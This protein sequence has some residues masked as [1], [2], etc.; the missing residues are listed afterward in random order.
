MRRIGVSIL[1]VALLATLVGFVVSRRLGTSASA[2]VDTTEAESGTGTGTGTTEAESGTGT[3]T[4]AEAESGTGTGTG[5][6]EAESGT[7]TGTGT[8]EAESGTGTG[9]GTREAESGTGTGTTEA[10]SGTGTG[11]EAGASVEPLLDRPLRVISTHWEVAAPILLASGGANSVEGS[12][13]DRAGLRQELRVSARAT[14][15]EEALARGGAEPNGADLAILP[16]ATWVAS[17]EHLAAL[18]TEVFFVAAW[19]RGSQVVFASPEATPSERLPASFGIASA[20][21]S[22]ESLSVLLLLSE[23]GVSPERVRFTASDDAAALLSA[24]EREGPDAELRARN[25]VP[26]LSTADASRLAPWVVVAPRGF[27]REHQPVLSAWAGAWLEGREMLARD[28]PAGARTIAAITG[29]PPL[30]DLLRR[31]GQIESIGLVEQAEL[32]GLSGRSY[33]TL[34]LLF[35][36][37]WSIDRAVGLL[38]GPPPEVLPIATG[39]IATLVRR[40]APTPPE[41]AG[42]RAAPEPRVLATFPLTLPRTSRGDT[43]DTDAAVARLGFVAGVFPRSGLRVIAPRQQAATARALADRAIEQYGLDPARLEFTTG[44][45]ASLRVLAPE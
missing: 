40:E 17:Y 20:R 7:G 22:A 10:E 8:T 24:A 43:S 12:V 35:R 30:V 38:S 21:G 14:D 19:S 3:G 4:G 23:M 36:R 34:E 16:L 6:T 33:V 42:F 15:V 25:R 1:L 18:E 11:T 9:T 32:A 45:T 5:T 41:R 44:T 31:L 2:V 13:L 39:T 26:W 27:V 29:A 28:V 37:A